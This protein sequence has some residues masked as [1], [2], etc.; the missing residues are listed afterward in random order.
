MK[1]MINSVA[2]I[3]LLACGAQAFADDSMSPATPTSRQMMKECI[4][5]QKTADVN[6]SKAAMKRMCK[7]QLKQ[8]K[9]SGTPVEAPPSDTPRT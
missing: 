2:F 5:K 1:R 6:M 8:Q 4:E 7:D 3:G 9:Q